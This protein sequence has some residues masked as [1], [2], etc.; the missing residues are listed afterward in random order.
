MRFNFG[1]NV[2]GKKPVFDFSVARMTLFG[3]LQ[4]A[5]KQN[6]A[7][8]HYSRAAIVEQ[9]GGKPCAIVVPPQNEHHYQ[10]DEQKC[11]DDYRP[12]D[13]AF[14]LLWHLSSVCGESGFW[15]AWQL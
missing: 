10:F 11:G 4:P 6:Y 3:F 12:A 5:V 1:V 9:R 7:D 8:E 13:S 2:A 14:I 15:Q